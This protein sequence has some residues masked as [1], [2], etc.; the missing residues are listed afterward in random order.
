MAGWLIAS[1]RVSEEGARRAERAAPAPRVGWLCS[2]TPVEILTATGTLPVRLLG[3]ANNEERARAFLPAALCPYLKACLGEALAAD[4]PPLDGLVVATGCDGLR[5]L[6]DVWNSYLPGFVYVLDVPRHRSAGA[7]SYFR[8]C[9]L[10]LAHFLSER[11]RRPITENALREAIAQRNRTRRLLVALDG[12]QQEGRALS[13]GQMLAIVDRSTREPP[14]TFNPWLADRL[15]RLQDEGHATPGIPIVV[16]GNVLASGD[17]HILDLVED[18]G[19]RVVGAYLCTGM[20]G[21]AGEVAGD[22]DPFLGLA[23]RYLE[24]VSCPRMADPT[25]RFG[26]LIRI[27]RDRGARGVLYLSQKFCDGSLYDFALLRDRL[28]REDIPVLLL[29]MDAGAAATGQARTR[30]EAFLELL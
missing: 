14:A 21:V 20:R 5:R 18:V 25:D 3:G 12:L 4:S 6:A 30:I 26:D 10:D 28:S 7:V 19:G 23:R 1:G 27:C 24:R 17:R 15:A 2:Y 8:S 9:L 22:G 29:E 13:A 11:Y 16:S